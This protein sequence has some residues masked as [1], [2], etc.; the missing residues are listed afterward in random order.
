[1]VPTTTMAV[2]AEAAAGAMM[3]RLLLVLLVLIP[4][5]LQ[6][7]WIINRPLDLP[8]WHWILKLNISVSKFRI[9]CSAPRPIIIID[10][11]FNEKKILGSANERPWPFFDTFGIAGVPRGD[12]FISL[13]LRLPFRPVSVRGDRRTQ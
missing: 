12:D 3:M 4:D 8:P 9:R 11:V 10:S 2:A 13:L 7:S 5:F 6:C 1:M